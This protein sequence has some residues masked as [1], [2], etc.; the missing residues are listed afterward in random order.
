MTITKEALERQKASLPIEWNWQLKKSP[1]WS[2]LAFLWIVTLPRRA[3]RASARREGPG[4]CTCGAGGPCPA[5]KYR[6][7]TIRRVIRPTLSVPMNEIGV[8]LQRNKR[9]QPGIILGIGSLVG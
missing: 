2:K 6:M 1:E 5:C 9:G 4:G 7:P 3:G 8:A